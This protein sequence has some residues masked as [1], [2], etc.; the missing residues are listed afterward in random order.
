M[1]LFVPV[2]L[3]LPVVPDLYFMCACSFSCVCDAWRRSLFTSQEDDGAIVVEAM[4]ARESNTEDCKDEVP[5]PESFIYKLSL[6][7]ETRQARRGSQWIDDKII[8]RI[9]RAGPVSCAPCICSTHLAGTSYTQHGALCLE[10]SID[11]LPAPC[12]YLSHSSS[13][14]SSSPV[15]FDRLS[16]VLKDRRRSELVSQVPSPQLFCA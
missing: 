2:V 14:S 15:Y 4:F 12:C 13:F 5:L 11:S 10:F 8:S 1:V 7:D 16:F 6:I 3:P 9:N